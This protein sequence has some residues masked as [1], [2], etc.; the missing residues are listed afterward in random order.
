MKL[1]NRNQ[2]HTIFTDVKRRLIVGLIL[3]MMGI[4]HAASTD[5]TLVSWVILHDLNVRAGSILTV[6]MGQQFDAIVFG[7][8]E[9]GKWIAGSDFFNRT[10]DDLSNV[11]LETADSLGK[12]IQM[13]IV[14]K[15]NTIRIYRNGILYTQYKADNIDLL[16]ADGNFATFGLRHVGGEGS[17]SGD[18]EDARIY[19]RALTVEELDALQPNKSSDIKPYAWWDFEGDE[20]IERTGKYVENTLSEN[21]EL[22]N[23]KL[24]LA[25]NGYLIARRPYVEETPEW[26][27]NPPIDW[28]TYHLVHP[29][30]G[31]AEPGG[32]VQEPNADLCLQSSD[33]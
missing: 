10:N 32:C 1:K 26:P 21:T 28:P 20:V 6:Q 7:E 11:S 8:I 31:R 18:I 19:D 17:I 15:G 29:G 23:G 4:T 24:R 30:P 12:M 2:Y 25:S 22:D 3:A 16:S 33:G 13:A 5:K 9:P 14:Y 27:K